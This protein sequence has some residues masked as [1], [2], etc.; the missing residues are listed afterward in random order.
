M[1]PCPNVG[2]LRLMAPEKLFLDMTSGVRAWLKKLTW[3]QPFFMHFTLNWRCSLDANFCP[4]KNDLFLC[5]QFIDPTRVTGGTVEYWMMNLKE[6]GNKWPWPCL[7]CY[8]SLG[9]S[10]KTIHARLFCFPVMIRKSH[11]LNQSSNCLHQ[12]DQTTLKLITKNFL[13]ITHKIEHNYISPSSTVGI[14]RHVSALYVG[15]LQVV[16]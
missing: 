9:R 1:A 11:L 5:V 2:D 3:R 13:C 8:P 7:R 6:S 4:V 10:D 14:Q 16:Y 12:P 15:H